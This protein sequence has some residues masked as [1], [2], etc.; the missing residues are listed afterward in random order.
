M[1]QYYLYPLSQRVMVYYLKIF[2]LIDFRDRGRGGEREKERQVDRQTDFDLL[3]HLF[4][5]SLI[6]SCVCADQGLNLEP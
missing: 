1:V 2:L 6:D 3:F 5:C 4:M